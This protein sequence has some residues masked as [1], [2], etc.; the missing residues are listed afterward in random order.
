MDLKEFARLREEAEVLRAR[1]DRAKGALGQKMK[2]LRRE[3]GVASLKDAEAL[4]TR[5]RK[6][7]ER[8]ARRR[9]EEMEAF[10][11]ALR[12]CRK[13]IPSDH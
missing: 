12:E 1:L 3:F 4:L 13:S 10:E 9:D 2:D 8:Q 5:T 11:E 6:E 7:E